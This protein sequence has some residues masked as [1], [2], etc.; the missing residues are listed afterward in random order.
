M[1]PPR[2][3]DLN[4]LLHGFHKQEQQFHRLIFSTSAFKIKLIVMNY[5]ENLTFISQ[6]LNQEPGFKFILLGSIFICNLLSF[7]CSTFNLI[8]NLCH[9]HNSLESQ[10]CQHYKK[11]FS[12]SWNIYNLINI[13]YNQN[14]SQKQVYQ[15][16]SSWLIIK[17]ITKESSQISHR[18]K[19]FISISLMFK[20]VSLYQNQFSNSMINIQIKNKLFINMDT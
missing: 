5:Y 20:E 12:L 14:A 9:I 1:Y 15:D 10:L 3:I 17:V 4:I 18:L 13:S 2:V 7:M 16:G 6:D 11:L 19:I 8:S